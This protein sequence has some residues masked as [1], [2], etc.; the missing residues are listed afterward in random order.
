M[1]DHKKLDERIELRNRTV[2]RV[3]GVPLRSAYDAYRAGGAELAREV[4]HLNWQGTLWYGY[5][6]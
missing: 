2:T 1:R 3:W 5:N 6:W 4:L